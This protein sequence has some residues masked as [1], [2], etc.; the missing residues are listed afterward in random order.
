MKKI[1]AENPQPQEITE[2]YFAKHLQTYPMPDPDIIIRT[3]GEMRLSGFLPWQGVYSELFFT[4]TLWPDF[5]KDEFQKIISEFG[6]R[7]RRNGK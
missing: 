2:E 4:P 5:P 6:E 7:D 1:V 3:S